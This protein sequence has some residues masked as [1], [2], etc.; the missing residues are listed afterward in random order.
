NH[1]EKKGEMHRTHNRADIADKV[2][3]QIEYCNESSV[4]YLRCYDQHNQTEQ[5]QQ[6]LVLLFS[7]S[8]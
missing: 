6:F 4:R 1:T 8:S 7:A 3:T 5:Q 2:W